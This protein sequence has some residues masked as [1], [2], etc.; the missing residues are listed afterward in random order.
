MA[1][2]YRV[3]IQIKESLKT[4]YLA[5]QNQT[6]AANI[7]FQLAFCYHIGFG[8]KPDDNKCHIRLD[9]SNKQLDD[10]KI[11]KEA[12]RPASGKS[13]SVRQLYG[14]LFK[15]NI[16]HEYRSRGL[17]KLEDALKDH[18][19]EASDMVQE[20]G[21]LHFV[22]LGLY[23]IIGDLLDAFGEF[24]KSIALRMRIRLQIRSTDGVVHDHPN[25][26]QSLLDVV[27]SHARLGEW[28][29][30]QQ[31]LEEVLKLTKSSQSLTVTPIRNDLALIFPNQGQL[32][33]AEEQSS[34]VMEIQTNVLGHE[35]HP[36]S[37][38]SMSNLAS[39]YISQE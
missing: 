34:Q 3:R 18:E 28:M 6:F 15:V 27:K 25:Y 5:N 9:K 24:A 23:T 29:E 38:T 8:V 14:L 36:S 33:K 26:I 12:V 1:T 16:T 13:G 2:D 4:N 21:E 39:I 10:V 35:H 19:R 31:L 7:A 37:L 22:L 17:D 30:A 11:E 20:Y 32:K